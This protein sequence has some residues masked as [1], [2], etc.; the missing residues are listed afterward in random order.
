MDLHQKKIL[1]ENFLSDQVVQKMLDK[2]CNTSQPYGARFC[3]LDS[4][5]TCHTCKLRAAP[6]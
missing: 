6:S 1:S 4:V 3:I 5:E 2:F